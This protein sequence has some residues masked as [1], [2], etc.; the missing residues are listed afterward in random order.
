MVGDEQV[1]HRE[2][3]YLDAWRHKDV[4]SEL[5]L[6]GRAAI[7]VQATAGRRHRVLPNEITES[8]AEHCDA[9][10][11]GQQVEVACQDHVLGPLAR[12]WAMRRDCSIRSGVSRLCGGAGVP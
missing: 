8:A 5:L 11:V 10:G 4:I 3:V 12:K 6:S 1:G 7:R 9:L 2:I